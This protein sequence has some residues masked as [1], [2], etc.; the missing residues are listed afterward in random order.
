MNSE[1]STTGP[2][3]V[4][5]VSVVLAPPAAVVEVVPDV[6]VVAFPV[7]AVESLA[8]VVVGAEVV[9]EVVEPLVVEV[10]VAGGEL[11][12]LVLT[13]AVLPVV[14]TLSVSFEESAAGELLQATAPTSRN[15]SKRDSVLF[16]ITAYH[17]LSCTPDDQSVSCNSKRVVLGQAPA[18][19]HQKARGEDAQ[20]R[21]GCLIVRHDRGAIDSRG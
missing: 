8:L 1:P 7:D 6:S 13:V 3:E 2:P 15:S 9:A 14:A 20:M 10:L 4:P 12:A 19:A 18:H 5:V 11:L 17:F 21:L 16:I